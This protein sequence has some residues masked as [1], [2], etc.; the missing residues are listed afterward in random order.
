[1]APDCWT[2]RGRYPDIAMRVQFKFNE[3][4]P[5]AERQ[6]LVRVVKRHGAASVEP[7]FPGESDPEL[8]SL[9]TAECPPEAD[10]GELISM[11]DSSDVIEFAEAEPTR[12]LIQGRRAGAGATNG[13]RTSG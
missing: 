6:E 13:R 5:V 1:M 7:L 11:L 8:A 10:G 2:S 9:Y 12:K 4:A 3:S